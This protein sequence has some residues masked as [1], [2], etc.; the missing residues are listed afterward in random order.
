MALRVNEG[1]AVGPAPGPGRMN[2]C[3]GGVVR[4]VRALSWAVVQVRYSSH[5]KLEETGR[6]VR[7]RQRQSKGQSTES[8]GSSA[9][10]FD[11]GFEAERKGQGMRCRSRNHGARWR[12]VVVG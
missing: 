8:S 11:I 4:V 9:S 10:G 6:I 12:R 1:L 5:Q 2:I 3:K 7:H